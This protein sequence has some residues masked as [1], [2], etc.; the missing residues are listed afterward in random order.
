MRL[1]ALTIG[2]LLAL[3][4]CA[5]PQ[6]VAVVAPPPPMPPPQQYSQP[7]PM[8]PPPPV[9]SE[10]PVTTVRKHRGTTTVSHRC[11]SGMHWVRGSKKSVT[12]YDGSRVVRVTKKKAGYCVS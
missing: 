7:Q 5:Q 12:H 9:Y 8:P 10:A 11:P 1:A 3:S 6:P 2:A 4:A